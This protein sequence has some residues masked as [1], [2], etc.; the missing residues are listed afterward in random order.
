[1]ALGGGGSLNLLNK[2][3]PLLAVLGSWLDSIDLAWTAS[4]EPPGRGPDLA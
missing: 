1:M 2:T 3:L 4:N